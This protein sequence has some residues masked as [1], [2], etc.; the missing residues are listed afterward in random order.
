M[1]IKKLTLSSHQEILYF[2]NKKF[3]DSPNL[4]S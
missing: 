3:A 1:D 2:I 4:F